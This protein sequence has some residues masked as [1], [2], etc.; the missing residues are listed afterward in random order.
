MEEYE[1]SFKVESINPYIEYCEKEGYEKIESSSQNRTLY[2]N[3]NKTMARITIKEKNGNKKTLL[4][5]KDD[6]QADEVL[7]VCRETMPLEI[8]EDNQ[9]AVDSIL[10][11]LEYTKD[12]TLI[13]NRQV[14]KK[15]NVIF[16]IDEYTSPEVMYVVA[17]EGEKTAV[18]KTYAT[19][20]ETINNEIPE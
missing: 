19:I 13:R 15:D 20:K 10:Y 2:R 7:K 17:I 4:D 12:K 16:E 3:V 6:N 9:K 1:Y 8:T 14:Y 18:D 11:Y 5:F